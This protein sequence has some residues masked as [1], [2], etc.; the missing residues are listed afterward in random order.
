MSFATVY[1]VNLFKILLHIRIM[2]EHTSHKYVSELYC[3]ALCLSTFLSFIWT[4]QEEYQP[5]RCH[6]TH[7]T[8]K[9][10]FRGGV[11]IWQFLTRR[12]SSD[13]LQ[14][15]SNRQPLLLK[16]L[17]VVATKSTF[18]LKIQCVGFSGIQ[19][20]A[21]RLQ[22]TK[23]IS[24][25]LSTQSPNLHLSY[26]TAWNEGCHDKDCSQRLISTFIQA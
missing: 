8:I 23:Y 21:C 9:W 14:Q 4:C 17:T 26:I 25:H 6:Q 7:L 11:R 12:S 10:Q 19:R 3:F 16:H 5:S 2:A 22:Q 15:Q 20:W 18:K 1:P 13:S 24:F